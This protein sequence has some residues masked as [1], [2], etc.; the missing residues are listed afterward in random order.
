MIRANDEPPLPDVGR[1]G[2]LQN[3]LRV[4]RPLQDVAVH[5]QTD[6]P[7]GTRLGVVELLKAEDGRH[8]LAFEAVPF[9]RGL[10]TSLSRLSRMTTTSPGIR[11]SMFLRFS[12]NSAFCRIVTDRVHE[13]AVPLSQVGHTFTLGDGVACGDQASSQ[14]SWSRSG[15]VTSFP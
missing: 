10:L 13:A 15:K 6:V 7:P 4:G 8:T 9:L 11:M 3:S 1:D 12:F 14:A 5:D 2:F